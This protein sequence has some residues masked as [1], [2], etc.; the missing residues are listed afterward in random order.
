MITE[1]SSPTQVERRL[2]ELLVA[3]VI[4]RQEYDQTLLTRESSSAPSNT[5]AP[6]VITAD[7][8]Y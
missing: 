8:C 7:A 1:A 6:R 5:T 4:T 2:V 3:K